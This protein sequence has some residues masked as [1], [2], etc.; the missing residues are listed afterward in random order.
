MSPGRKPEPLPGLHGRPREHDSLHASLDEVR[1]RHGH[2][3]VGLAGA[4]R[5]DTDDDIVVAD[6]LDVALLA[7]VLRGDDPV[8]GR[9]V[10]GVPEDLPQGHALGGELR[11]LVDVL[12][13][14]GVA[15][16]HEFVELSHHLLGHAA[17]PLVPAGHHDLVAPRADLDSQPLFDELQVLLVGPGQHPDL[18]VVGELDSDGSGRLSGLGQSTSSDSA[19][20]P[21]RG[22]ASVRRGA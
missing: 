17:A 14:E 4:G 16:I 5:A 2:G 10:D 7:Q 6:R 9:H 13:V 12:E 22:R 8:P 3:E 15:A 1:H 11:R 21:G 18:V 19:R 20:L